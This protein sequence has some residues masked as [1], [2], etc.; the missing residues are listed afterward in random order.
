M[1]FIYFIIFIIGQRLLELVIAKHNE[2][3]IRKQGALEYGQKHYS[4]IVLLHTFFIIAL[5]IEYWY[6]GGHFNRVF[7]IIF[8]ILL[9]LKIWTIFSLGKYWNTKILKIPHSVFVKKGPYK[10]FKHPN[11]FIVVCEFV[12]IPLVFNLYLTAII[13]SALNAIMLMVRIREEEKVWA[14]I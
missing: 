14:N 6:R 1:N 2:K 10:Y 13:F 12:V 7:M 5:T 9:L 11:Y 8:L 4:S 3:W